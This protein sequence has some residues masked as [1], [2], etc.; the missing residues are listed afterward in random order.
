MSALWR[1]MFGSDEARLVVDEEE[2]PEISALIREIEDS[3]RSTAEAHAL[4]EAR[5]R[6][7]SDERDEWRAR[8][9]VPD[10]TA[11]REALLLAHA[12]GDVAA[13]GKLRELDARRD[14]DRLRAESASAKLREVDRRLA[15]ANIALAEAASAR[16]R[17]VTDLA[18]ARQH[19]EDHKVNKELN[20]RMDR[21]VAAALSLEAEKREVRA[22]AA[23]INRVGS[24]RAL[25]GFDA[26]Y[27]R[28]MGL[29]AEID[30]A[31][32]ALAPE[33][34]V[35][36]HEPQPVQ[37]M[38]AGAVTSIGMPRGTGASLVDHDSKIRMFS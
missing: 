22:F 21:L 9:S 14:D 11:E 34:Q 15:E 32:G 7:L 18:L 16:D 35:V 36:V 1:R 6:A 4:A 23:R 13:L 25:P 19:V 10:K 28:V 24:W 20:A 29:A 27:R 30:A 33:Q 37:R 31:V 38:P 17:A 5:H 12:E 2:G 3:V 26:N 8:A